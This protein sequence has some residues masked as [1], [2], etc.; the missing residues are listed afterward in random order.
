MIVD[1]V[2]GII[3]F[4]QSKLLKKYLTISAQKRNKA[5]TDFEKDFYKTFNNAFYGKKTENVRN[6]WRLEITEK[7]DYKKNK[8]T[9]IK[10]NLQRIS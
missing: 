9:T 7:D 2:H 3:Y 1:K 5:N 10:T 8:K 6:R 4:K